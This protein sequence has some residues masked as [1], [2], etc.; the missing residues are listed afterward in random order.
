MAVNLHHNI[1][2]AIT[3]EL[4]SAGSNIKVSSVSLCNVSDANACRIDLYIQK[5]NGGIF[6]Y[7]K[8]VNIPVGTSL[9][10]NLNFDNS[11]DEYGLYVKLTGTSPMIDIIIR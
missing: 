6:Y 8:R 2:G 11:K 4:L 5:Q 1:T 3:Q 10:Q 9:F 7:L